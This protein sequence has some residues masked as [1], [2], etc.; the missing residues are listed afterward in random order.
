MYT[1]ENHSQKRKFVY[2]FPA[3]VLSFRFSSNVY[4]KTNDE[5]IDDLNS[6]TF[7]KSIIW[8][9]LRFLK[10]DAKYNTSYA[11]KFLTP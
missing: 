3:E 4:N 1:I 10:F 5:R 9:L 2:T 6:S 7:S 11:A 8:Q